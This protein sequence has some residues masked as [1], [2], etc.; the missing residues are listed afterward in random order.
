MRMFVREESSYIYILI[1]I[2]R[3]LFKFILIIHIYKITY[4]L[5]LFFFLSLSF[6]LSFFLSNQFI[7]PSFKIFFSLK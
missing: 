1:Y 5:F 3:T 6:F 2:L 7:Y 4:P